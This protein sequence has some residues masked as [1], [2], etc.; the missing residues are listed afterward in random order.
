MERERDNI[1]IGNRLLLSEKL[2]FLISRRAARTSFRSEELDEYSL[3]RPIRRSRL[4]VRALGI[5]TRGLER[6]N[7]QCEQADKLHHIV[8]SF[9]CGDILSFGALFR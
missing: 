9:E 2:E 3:R 5:D 4:H 6:K 7:D 1:G 8:V